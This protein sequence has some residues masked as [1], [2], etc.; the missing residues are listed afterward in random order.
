MG[1]VVIEGP[2]PR[3]WQLGVVVRNGARYL[4][5]GAVRNWIRNI[6]GTA[7]ALGSM[8][9]LLLLSGLVG[10]TGFAM[11]NLA[12]TE[13]HDASLLH[14]YLR[15]DAT[16]DQVAALRARI[17]ADHRVAGVGYT[18]KAQ[19]LARAQRR[20][21]LPELVDATDSNPFPASLDVQVKQ[22]S[23]VGAIDALVRDDP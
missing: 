21:G 16:D 12:V 1:S 10:L 6:G 23:D 4:F 3:R 7:P 19:A 9:L 2:F 15:D 22:V 8:T 17:E 5:R 13:A 11:R 14:V 20:P 18:T